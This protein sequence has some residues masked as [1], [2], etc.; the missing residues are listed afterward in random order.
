M[1]NEALYDFYCS[2][3]IQVI[4]P[5]RKWARHMVQEG[6]LW[7]WFWWGNVRERDTLEDLDGSIISKWILKKEYEGMNWIYLAQDDIEGTV[8]VRNIADNSLT[9]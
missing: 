5:R 6:E 7:V 4:K 1:H 3:D 2:P 8:V 9:R